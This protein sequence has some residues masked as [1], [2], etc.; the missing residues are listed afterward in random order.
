MYL[1][2]GQII[3]APQ[4]G[5]DV[6]IDPLSWPGSWSPPAPPPCPT[7][8]D[9]LRED[10]TMPVTIAQLRDTTSVDLMTAALVGRPVRQLVIPPRW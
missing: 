5:E 6:Q 2:G 4:T 1:G 9:R 3:Q 10:P 8:P 7:P